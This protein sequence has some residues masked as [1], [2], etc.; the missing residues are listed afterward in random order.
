[1]QKRHGFA[2]DADSW[3][4]RVVDDD[5]FKFGKAVQEWHCIYQISCR[6]SGRKDEVTAHCHPFVAA[7]PEVEDVQMAELCNH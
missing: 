7:T 4:G 6:Y 5:V 2:T 3:N 1:M